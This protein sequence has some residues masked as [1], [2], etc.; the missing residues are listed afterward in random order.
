[1]LWMLSSVSLGLA[2]FSG[3]LLTADCISSERRDDTLG[4]L[5]L[6]N[7]KGYDVVTGKISSHAITTACGLLAVFPVFFLPILAGGASWAETLR[8]LLAITVS[9]LFALTLGVWISA[10][11]RDAKN[12]VMATLTALLLIV[13]L[14][15]LWIAIL[16]EFFR[17]RPSMVGVP[18]LSPG[19][20][21][22][23]G[24]DFWYLTPKA[25][26]VYWISIGMFVIASAVFAALASRQLPRV[27]RHQEGSPRTDSATKR[28][29][30]P[31][32]PLP[33][34]RFNRRVMIRPAPVR[35]RFRPISPNPFRDLLL[36]RLN[37]LAWG[38][39]VRR[40]TTWFVLL[41]LFSSFTAGDEE[42][43]VIAVMTLFLM[44]VAAKFV[45]AFDATRALGDQK[46]SSA[47]ELLLVTPIGE[48]GIADAQSSAFYIQFRRH[49][50]RMVALTLAVQFTMVA[51]DSLRLRG[52]D[53]FLLSSFIWGAMIWTWSDYRTIPWLGMY[54]ALKE[55]THLK[56]TLR[57]LGGMLL[58]WAPYFLI[59]FFMANA[60]ADETAAG[61]V[62]FTWA[63]CGA[64]YQAA[65]RHSLRARLV[66]EFRLLVACP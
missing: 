11:S 57:T 50:R 33:F 18:Q 6:T 31:T 12:A 59:L 13:T 40:L 15:L 1:M 58:P 19:M 56:A 48:R 49:M 9:F 55:S 38:K 65:R 23:Y 36:H 34:L 2:L 7:L 17:V 35:H 52:D 60:N 26:A 66:R 53:L 21:L 47:L 3:G 20:L 44:H 22:Y 54:R 39:W 32:N 5:F 63:I 41:M 37:E 27:W 28:A 43:F 10:R 45:F 16:D 8:V 30:F 25:K 64:I 4:F 51:N 42:P 14:P 29:D 61:L 24:R 62:T 46:R